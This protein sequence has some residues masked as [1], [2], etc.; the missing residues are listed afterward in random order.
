VF[1]VSA[2]DQEWLAV[3]FG[4]IPGYELGER[5]LRFHGKEDS[6]IQSCC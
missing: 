6:P 4:P 3:M 5:Q 1:G 2:L